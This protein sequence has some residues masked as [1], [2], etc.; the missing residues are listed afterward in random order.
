MYLSRRTV[1]TGLVCALGVRPVQATPDLMEAAIADFA[2][3]RPMKPGRVKLDLPPLVENG[4]A[5]PLTV[6]VESPMSADDFIARI[7]LFNEKNPQPNIAV[8]HLTPFSGRAAVST[9][10]RLGDSQFIT[11]IA[12]TNKGELFVT[13]AELV[14]TLPA[15]AEN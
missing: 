13:K 9:R 5:V 12:E 8:F 11:A 2:K 14:V 7:A 10:I 1:L 4:N 3:G 6:S 15:C